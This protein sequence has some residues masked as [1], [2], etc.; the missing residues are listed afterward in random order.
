[1]IIDSLPDIQGHEVARRGG[2]SETILLD[3]LT[4]RR[5]EEPARGRG[6]RFDAHVLKPDLDE[7][8]Q[9]LARRAPKADAP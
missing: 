3:R 2:Q 6:G 9:A 8:A 7:L 5:A 4:V 1:M